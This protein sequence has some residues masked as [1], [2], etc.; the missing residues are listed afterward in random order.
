MA[1]IGDRVAIAANKVGQV[2]RE[3][4][5]RAKTG[6]LIRI[7]WDSGEESTIMPAPGTLTVVRRGRGAG[8]AKKAAPS[9]A[10]AAKKPAPAKKAAPG[11][12]TASAKKAAPAKTAL[13][14][15]KPAPSKSPAKKA[16][17]PKAL[18]TKKPAPT[19]KA[20]AAKKAGGRKR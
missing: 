5:V 9:K 7:E 16:P 8:G 2:P 6:N 10:G 18:V 13:V 11:K 1:E 17:A 3:G 12:K 20:G 19:K 4:I 15:K 14:T